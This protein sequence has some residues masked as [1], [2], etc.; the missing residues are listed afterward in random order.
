MGNSPGKPGHTPVQYQP[1]ESNAIRRLTACTCILAVAAVATALALYLQQRS[2][3]KRIV[4]ASE[5]AEDRLERLVDDEKTLSAC[6]IAI[7]EKEVIVC[8]GPGE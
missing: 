6:N 3:E 2:Q 5:L 7:P 4:R 8:P 1:P